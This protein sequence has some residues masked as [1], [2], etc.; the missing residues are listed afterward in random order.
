MRLYLTILRDRFPVIHKQHLQ[1]LGNIQLHLRL[2][3]AIILI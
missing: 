3:A 1:Y 2:L